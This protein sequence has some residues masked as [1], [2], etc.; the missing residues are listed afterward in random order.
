[1][2]TEQGWKELFQADRMIQ[3]PNF[4]KI[5]ANIE[6]RKIRRKVAP[7]KSVVAFS[8]GILAVMLFVVS[9]SNADTFKKLFYL[10]VGDGEI[11]VV[12]EDNEVQKD[13]SHDYEV[14]KEYL[15][16]A[17]IDE[18]SQLMGVKI[19]PPSY[20][21]DGYSLVSENG[22]STI[23]NYTPEGEL[24]SIE[25]DPN[26]NYIYYPLEMDKTDWEKMIV[27]LY[28]TSEIPGKNKGQA[29]HRKNAEKIEIQGLQGI[30]YKN[31]VLV[32]KELD[33]HLVVIEIRVPTQ[34]ANESIK[35]MESIVEN[36][37]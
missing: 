9:I 24:I 28:S 36:I 20:I 25:E 13:G 6:E 31:G 22:I 26:Y 7:F 1:M 14:K 15:K 27:V 21:P 18:V 11:R 32:F 33:E 2:K 12:N 34:Y 8:T 23:P 10:S 29:F 16:E 37:K 35:M 5:W 30:K 3:E 4:N 17:T 19:I